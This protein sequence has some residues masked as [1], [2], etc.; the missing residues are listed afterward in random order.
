MKWIAIA[1]VLFLSACALSPEAVKPPLTVWIGVAGASMMPEY[2]NGCW[3]EIDINYPFSDLREGDDIVWRDWTQDN[4]PE[5]T[6]HRI[7]AVRGNY[8]TTKGVNKFTNP[9]PD[10]QRITKEEF[11]GRATGRKAL[12][13]APPLPIP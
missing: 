13:L 8:V 10:K 9:H 11:V 3:V 6:F 12:F 5:Y 7:V 2:P 4:G 1:L